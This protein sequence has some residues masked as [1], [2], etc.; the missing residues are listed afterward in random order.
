MK[1]IVI[2]F[3][4]ILTIASNVHSQEIPYGQEFQV[5]T[6]SQN[7]QEH[8]SI[9]TL[10]NKSFIVCWESW[11][12]D[13]FPSGIF[14]QIFDSSST[15]KNLEF[16]I[17]A[18]V[19][20]GQAYPKVI[21]LKT[22]DFVVSWLRCCWDDSGYEIFGQMYD[23]A[24]NKKGNEFQINTYSQGNQVYAEMAP[25]KNGDFVI[26][27]DSEN[28]DGSERGI[29]GQIFH[30]AG[31]KKGDEFQINSFTQ[32]SQVCPQVVPLLN[33]G[34][35]VCWFCWLGTDND[36]TGTAIFG[37]LFDSIGIKNG[38]EF[39]VNTYNQ[40]ISNTPK[41]TSLKNGNFIISWISEKHDDSEANIYGQAFDSNG[42]S[43]NFSF[44]INIPRLYFLDSHVIEALPNGGFIV[45]WSSYL[46]GGIFGQYFDSLGIKIEKEFCIKGRKEF[47][48]WFPRV[49]SF[50]DGDIV[51][52]W[53]IQ[54]QDGSDEGVFAKILPK[55]PLVHNLI[56]YDLLLPQND[57]TMR[58]CR[59]LFNWQQP[60]KTRE[61][62]PWELTFDLYI[63]TDINF[64]NPQI[65]NNIQDTTY[66]ID[67][68][69]AG[70][71]Y[72]WKV[73]AKNLAGDSFWS[74]QQDWGFFISHNA[75]SVETADENLPQ[76]FEL[77]QN[78]PN[79]FNSSTEIRYSIPQVSSSQHVLI[80]IY[81]IRGRLV[82]VLVDQDQSS[83][84]HTVSW[85][86][87]DLNGNGVSSGIYFYTLQ[88]GELKEPK[89]MLLLE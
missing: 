77:F 59:I 4:L 83:G 42:I 11:G 47:D 53:N 38:T 58:T 74:T 8:P 35:A 46:Q 26:C 36:S 57:V 40:D 3:I 88:V 55:K 82:K 17:Y 81:D 21:S 44:Q 70:K 12:Q 34:F 2:G 19:N 18:H 41:M 61:C 13:G 32:G 87:K 79:P 29:F 45:C 43:N 80:K 49:A 65:I 62:Y 10:E 28:Q 33:G 9:A 31:K 86:G 52:C 89:K 71:T 76:Q 84:I 39:E 78:Y 23:S 24:G 69:A 22:G 50:T 15:K 63:D 67:S 16:Q 1:N 66:T 64:S 5:N 14:G 68:L 72:F 56:G 6:Y 27:W 51:A 60:S 7:V 30:S 75:T 37:Q 48:P 85:D 54:E 73:L 20:Q 25:L